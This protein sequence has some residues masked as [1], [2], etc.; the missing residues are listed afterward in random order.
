MLFSPLKSFSHFEIGISFNTYNFQMLG[1]YECQ[2][3]FFKY[4]LIFTAGSMLLIGGWFINQTEFYYL[5]EF[6][7]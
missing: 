2:Y 4:Y 3:Y 7:S 1:F 6:M 5:I